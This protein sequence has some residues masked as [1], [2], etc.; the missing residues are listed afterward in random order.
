[1]EARSDHRRRLRRRC[2]SLA[3]KSTAPDSNDD[4][5]AGAVHFSADRHSLKRWSRLAGR[6]HTWHCRSN[7]LRSVRLYTAR[8]TA[9]GGP[10]VSIN[11]HG[12][13]AVLLSIDSSRYLVQL[14]PM[15]CQIL[16]ASK[17]H[18][19]E[20]TADFRTRDLHVN[21][22]RAGPFKLWMASESAFWV[23]CSY[24]GVFHS[25][26]YSCAACGLRN[27]CAHFSNIYSFRQR[28]LLGKFIVRGESF[29]TRCFAIVLTVPYR[30]MS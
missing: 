3:V 8:P 2:Q 4:Y 5:P 22:T 17:A 13:C 26:H 28:Q 21:C 30:K 24:T 7:P 16:H 20:F 18:F 23:R 19:A 29:N 11:S 15:R 6:P 10:C 1:M 14:D 27:S 25:T 9:A 12:H